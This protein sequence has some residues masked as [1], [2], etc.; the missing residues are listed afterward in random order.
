MGVTVPPQVDVM[1]SMLG[2]PWPNVDEDEIRKDADAWRTVLA[3]TDRSGAAANA[4]I[5]G[6]GDVYRGR[7][8]TAL[9]GYWSETGG[10]GGHLS[11]AAA[12]ARLAPA[13]LDNTAWLTTGVKVAVASTAV[14]TTVRVA[15]AYLAGGPLGAALA[16]AEMFRSRAAIGKIQREGAEGAGRV[17]APALDRRVTEQFR[18]ILEGLR[19]P[20]GGGPVPAFAGAGHRIPARGTVGP[21]A[22]TGRSPQDGLALMG[23][24]NKNAR[25]GG[26][27][28]RGGGGG[29]SGGGGG[30]RAGGDGRT[31]H[32]EQR[33]SQRGFSDDMIDDVKANGR[34]SRGHDP[35]TS[36]YETDKLKVVVNDR[37]GNVI[38]VIRKKK[39]RN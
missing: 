9:A 16:A 27:G 31:A 8:A 7:S 35:G 39:R 3:G 22:A 29:R 10:E 24:S 25:S 37:T 21:R 19:R 28:R 38:T 20:G 6:T 11:R 18:R 13:V 15:R 33:Q 5:A 12:A 17:L 34:R 30:A 36:V 23:R 1:L 14:Y 26:N 2:M 4:T 32:S